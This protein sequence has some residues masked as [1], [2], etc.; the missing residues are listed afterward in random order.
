MDEDIIKKLDLVKTE[1]TYGLSLKYGVVVYR[2]R[3][4]DI[5]VVEADSVGYPSKDLI[6]FFK[7]NKFI[8]LTKSFILDCPMRELSM[9]LKINLNE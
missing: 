4:T 9:I 6:M 3:G 5:Y 1:L 2:R 7:D 8:K